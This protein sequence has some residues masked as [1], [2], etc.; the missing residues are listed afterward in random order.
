MSERIQPR[1]PVRGRALLAS[2]A[3]AAVALG[4]G[5]RAPA[6]AAA[7]RG[8]I[9]LITIDALRAD[10]LGVFGGPPRLTPHLD[11]L[12]H[13]ASWAGRAISAS[14]WTIPSMA[15]IMT[16]LQV[17][18]HGNWHG[19]RPVLAPELETL[20]EALKA[21]G[22]ATAAFRSNHWLQEEY[23]YAQ[24]FDVFRYLREGRR[25]EQ[26]LSRL[27]GGPQFVWVHILPPHAPYVLHDNLVSRLDDPPSDLPRRVAPLDLEPYY[28]PSVPAPP[29]ILRRFRAMYWLN[30]AWA[31]QI[32][33]RM[34]AALRASGH[35]DDALVVVTSDHGE[36]FK[37]HGQVEHGGNL[38][39]AL[40]EV[41]LI[42]KLP[43]GS[44]RRLAIPAGSRPANLR[45]Y[46][47]LVEAAGGTPGPDVAPSLFTAAPGPVLSELYLGD[48]SNDFSL[49]VGDRQLLWQSRFA[50]PD[51]EFY[52]AK[53]ESLGG[54]PRP[55]LR[56]P[57][58]SI[59]ARQGAAFDR[60]L[61]L[62]GARDLPPTFRLEQWTADGR[63]VTIQDAA[64][65]DRMA[66]ELRALWLLLNGPETLPS[67]RTALARPKL[68][69]EDEAELR[70]LGYVGGGPP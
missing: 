44:T 49:V 13:Q 48:G 9:V 68:S 28:D 60:T 6:P 4:C 27:D 29:E 63:S 25:A 61:P 20:A 64:A 32:F 30:A 66:R 38:G 7:H 62:T 67:Q 31:D 16:G 26:A 70:A 36:E 57:P 19:G 21:S 5:H 34:M 39:R 37:E 59:F 65:T 12:A 22:Y 46:A 14:S 24:G 42:V 47:T 69:P 40:I 55:A 51:A 33:G 23:G 54:A 2:V 17:W 1:R 15:S 50:V 52:R 43:K 45:V 11:E 53:F 18:R 35:F 58:D 10:A 8:P 41:P 3:L 56:E